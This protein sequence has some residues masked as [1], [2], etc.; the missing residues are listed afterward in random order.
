MSN[1][2]ESKRL[3]K[4]FF[5]ETPKEE[6]KAMIDKIDRDNTNHNDQP[7]R[8]IKTEASGDKI[9]LFF[10][11]ELITKRLAQIEE[12]KMV[13]I[14]FANFVGN[15]PLPEY[16]E[17]TNKWRWWNNDT[18]E[19]NFATTEELFDLFIQQYKP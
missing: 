3:L 15:R 2:D 7:V 16:S 6:I 11:A 5:S 9:P 18:R 17:S 10:T 1:I 4:K 12:S 13:A 19:Y 8:V 14:A